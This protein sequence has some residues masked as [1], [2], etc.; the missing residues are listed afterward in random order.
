MGEILKCKKRAGNAG[1]VMHLHIP[2]AYKVVLHQ[3]FTKT[4]LEFGKKYC[5]RF[6]GGKS[7]I[8]IAKKC[9]L[10]KKFFS[11]NIKHLLYR[12]DAERNGASL[13]PSRKNEPL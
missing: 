10:V 4:H 1:H 3:Q 12:I 7:N 13:N 9:P 6:L 8:I 11:G 2:H 5:Y